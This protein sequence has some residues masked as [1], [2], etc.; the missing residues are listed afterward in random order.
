MAAV[1]LPPLLL[2]SL[3][4]RNAAILNK[5]NLSDFAGFRHVSLNPLTVQHDVSTSGPHLWFAIGS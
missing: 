4:R 2:V 5:V 1:G 3:L